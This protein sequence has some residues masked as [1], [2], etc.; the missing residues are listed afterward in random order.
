MCRRMARRICIRN[1]RHP[2]RPKAP[3]LVVTANTE[4]PTADDRRRNPEHE[5]A[6]AFLRAGSRRSRFLH[7]SER[8]HRLQS[9]RSRLQRMEPSARR[10]LHLVRKF[11]RQHRPSRRIDLAARHVPRAGSTKGKPNH[12]TDVVSKRSTKIHF[13]GSS[14]RMFANI[15]KKP[16]VL[17]HV[18]PDRSCARKSASV[19]VQND[20]CNGCGYCVVSCPFGVI[21]RRPEPLPDAGGAFKCT[22]CYDRQKSGLVPACA[23]VCPTESIVFGRLD[24]LRARAR[25]ARGATASKMVT[26]TRSFTIRWKRPCAAFTRSF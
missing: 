16:V 11:L 13:A 26:T 4:R 10:R 23:K 3:Q 21:D 18:R 24:D 9:L 22:F 20:V 17:K 1:N 12:R 14:C 15:A 7:R 5:S 2:A 6:E 19:L 8:L 25:K